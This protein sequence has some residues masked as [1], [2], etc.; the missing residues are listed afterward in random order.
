MESAQN[1]EMAQKTRKY[2]WGRLTVIGDMTQASA[3]IRY[4]IDDGEVH[5][6][7]LQTSDARHDWREAF[8]LVNDILAREV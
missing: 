3:P 7:P 5:A 4:Q 1:T 6:T 8:R 2:A